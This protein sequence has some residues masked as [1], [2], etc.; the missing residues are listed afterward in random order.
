MQEKQPPLLVPIPVVERLPLSDRE[1]VVEYSLACPTR[2]I[3]IERDKRFYVASN[4]ITDRVTHWYEPVPLEQFVAPLTAAIPY[5]EEMEADNIHDPKVGLWKDDDLTA[6][7]MGLQNLKNF[8]RP[9][10]IS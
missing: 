3:F 6:A 2:A 5:M 4:D 10:G 1:V 8:L 7:V 9:G